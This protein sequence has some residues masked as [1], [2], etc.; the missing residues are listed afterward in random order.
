M[1]QFPHDEFAKDWLRILLCAF[2]NV[3]IERPVGSEVRAIDCWFSP[4]PN[5]TL[6]PEIGI[7]QGLATTETAFE[8]YRNPASAD[9]LRTCLA[10]LF[11]LFSEINRTHKAQK[12]PKLKPHLLPYQWLITPTFSATTLQNF[13][14]IIDITLVEAGIYRLPTGNCTGIIIVHDLPITPDTLCL[15]VL[16]RD[17]VQAQALQ[18]IS[19]LPTN[20]PYRKQALEIISAL[21]TNL[22]NSTKRSKPDEELLMSLLTSPAHLEF[23]AKITEQGEARGEARGQAEATRSITLHQLT[24]KFGSLPEVVKAQVAALPLDQAQSLTEAL[25]DFESI[26]DLIAWL[27]A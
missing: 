19:A 21:K 10:R 9:D 12:L 5:T 27:Q 7:L 11:G 4:T 14:A 17:K 20:S 2:G 15:R 23:V 26:D 18:E 6:P 25:L 24:K 16:G 1:S 22:E 3:E 13:G 8:F